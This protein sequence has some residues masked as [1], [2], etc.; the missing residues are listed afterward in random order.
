M[1]VE[2]SERRSSSD[3]AGEPTHGTLWSQGRRRITELLEG[4]MPETSGSRRISTQLEQVAKLAREAPDMAF[5]TLAH[6]ID[7]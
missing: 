6:L 3:E 5:T 7:I 2:E 4:K 1:G